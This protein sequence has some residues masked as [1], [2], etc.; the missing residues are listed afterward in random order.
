MSS[1]STTAATTAALLLAALAATARGDLGPYRGLRS[2]DSPHPQDPG[3]VEFTL[4]VG[5]SDH[6]VIHRDQ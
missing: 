3:C 5:D 2:A 6:S 4:Q 1:T